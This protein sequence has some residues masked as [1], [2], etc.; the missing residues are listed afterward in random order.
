[1]ETHHNIH[2][3]ENFQVRTCIDILLLY[4]IVKMTLLIVVVVMVQLL[5][6]NYGK[7]QNW[8]GSLSVAICQQSRPK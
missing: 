4:N 7:N 3:S 8:T 6:S 2:H 1:M 5:F